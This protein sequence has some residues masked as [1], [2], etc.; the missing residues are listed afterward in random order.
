MT[1]WLR[2]ALSVPGLDPE[3]RA[4]AS[5]M[6]LRVTQAMIDRPYYHGSF[7]LLRAYPPQQM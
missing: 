3:L 4:S 7:I 6:M 2:T 5:G 1:R